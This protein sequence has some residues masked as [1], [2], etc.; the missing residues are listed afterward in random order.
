LRSTLLQAL[1]GMAVRPRGGKGASGDQKRWTAE[2]PPRS[3]TS[4]ARSGAPAVW[5]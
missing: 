4:D 1:A 3:G 5:Q 2:S